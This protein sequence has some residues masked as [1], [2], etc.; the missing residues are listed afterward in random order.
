NAYL[1]QFRILCTVR[2]L[3]STV[4]QKVN[5]GGQELN[6]REQAEKLTRVIFDSGS[7]YTC[8]PHEIYTSLIALVRFCINSLHLVKRVQLI[9]CCMYL[10]KIL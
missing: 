4:L 7:S 9:P 10:V 6:V 2:N 5:Y 3:Y 1:T 8:F